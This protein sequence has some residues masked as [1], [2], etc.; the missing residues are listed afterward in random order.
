MRIITRNQLSNLSNRDIKWYLLDEKLWITKYYEYADVEDSIEWSIGSFNWLCEVNDTLL[1]NK[2]NGRFETAIIDLSEK[3]VIADIDD[4][5]LSIKKEQKGEL[6]LKEKK[7]CNFEFSSMVIYQKKWDCLVSF[8]TNFVNQNL[9]I[10][11][12][13]S[14]FGFIIMNDQLKGWI[15]K[16][17][18]K[19]ICTSEANENLYDNHIDLL[20]DYLYALNLWEEN[21]ENDTNL[22]ELMDIVK[23]KQDTISLAIK[24]CIT[25]IL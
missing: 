25:N 7:N 15:L 23:T 8:P 11:Y 5:F 20:V 9:E 16:N 13:V 19:H 10:V 17:A 21:E 24:E 18:S 1:F 3:I 4:L 12:I 14:D 22:K 2:E 6:F